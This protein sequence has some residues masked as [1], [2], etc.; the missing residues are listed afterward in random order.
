VTR[1]ERRGDDPERRTHPWGQGFV[2]SPAWA[3]MIAFPPHESASQ[4]AHRAEFIVRSIDEAH[5]C[6]ASRTFGHR[7]QTSLSPREI[8]SAT[9]AF[10]IFFGEFV[11]PDELSRPL[12]LL[13][14]SNLAAKGTLFAA[15]LPLGI[16]SVYYREIGSDARPDSDRTAIVRR[17]LGKRPRGVFTICHGGDPRV[18][19]LGFAFAQRLAALQPTAIGTAGFIPGSIYLAQRTQAP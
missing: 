15:E 9:T 8:V 10:E 7:M 14:G 16:R 18:R 4:R 12:M 5:Y 17:A 2:P 13:G 3:G 1:D 19:D 11:P 6:T